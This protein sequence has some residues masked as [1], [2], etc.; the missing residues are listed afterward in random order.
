MP[1]NP[2]TRLINLFSNAF[3]DH[4]A[5]HM[6]IKDDLLD[7]LHWLRQ[8]N[9]VLLGLMWGFMGVTGFIGF[10]AHIAL[11]SVAIFGWY[12]RQRIDEEDYGGHGSLLSEGL[13]PS[14]SLFLLTWITT[15]TMLQA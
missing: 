6:W 1:A 3:T 13:A 11:G 12:R 8:A 9:A 2:F 4:P 14:M 5:G 15:Y 10:L 7:T